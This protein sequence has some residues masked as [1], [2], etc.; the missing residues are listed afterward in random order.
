MSGIQA[1]VNGEGT[2]EARTLP[3]QGSFGITRPERLI[4]AMT[5]PA[6]FREARTGPMA[7]GALGTERMKARRRPEVSGIELALMHLPSPASASGRGFLHDLV[8]TKTEAPM[9]SDYPWTRGNARGVLLPSFAVL[10]EGA[11]AP[12]GQGV[13]PAPEMPRSVPP[14]AE[15]A[16]TVV[17]PVVDRPRVPRTVGGHPDGPGKGQTP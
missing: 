5:R 3:L 6:G 17:D 9:D 1:H 8:Q 10:A 13:G 14:L 2:A 15:L 11:S 12:V 7:L 16:D 4:G